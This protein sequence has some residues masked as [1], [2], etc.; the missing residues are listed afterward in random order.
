M[1]SVPARHARAPDGAADPS[2][3]WL[4]VGVSGALSIVT[5]LPLARTGATHDA[6]ARI[7][8]E[9]AFPLFGRA[10]PERRTFLFT[11]PGVRPRSAALDDFVAWLIGALQMDVS[12]LV[13]AYALYELL[14]TRNSAVQRPCSVRPVFL[15][16]AALAAMHGSDRGAFG[17]AAEA[18]AALAENGL[19]LSAPEF[20]ALVWHAFSCA[21]HRIPNSVRGGGIAIDYCLYFTHLSAFAAELNGPSRHE[22]TDVYEN[23]YHNCPDMTPKSESQRP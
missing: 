13:V 17:C 23:L 6:L 12:E 8:D 9:R 19:D 2:A 3:L 11:T 4:G 14:V 22:R 18:W 21:G 20:D 7:L 5:E 15:G 10:A 16:C 1:A